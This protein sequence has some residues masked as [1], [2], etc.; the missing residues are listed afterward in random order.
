MLKTFLTFYMIFKIFF[1]SYSLSIINANQSLVKRLRDRERGLGD[2]QG[3]PIRWG[4]R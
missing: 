2:R 4:G 3:S 1:Q